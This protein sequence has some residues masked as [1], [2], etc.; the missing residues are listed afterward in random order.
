MNAR[1]SRLRAEVA[2]D[3]RAF[4]DRVAEMSTLP[5]LPGSGPGELA[6]VAVAL[7]HAYGA[8]EGAFER[9]CRVIEG[10][11]PEGRDSHQALLESMSLEIAGIRPAVVSMMAL[12]DLRRLLSFRHF[13]RHAY[14]VNLDPVRLE[15][16]RSRA[17]ALAPVLAADLDRFD[18]F[19]AELERAQ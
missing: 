8:V 14:V 1:I 6:R 16:V 10:S 5:L 2:S 18:T 19:L 17:L 11:V 15:E 4:T 12:G 13:F 3:R 9:I 7:H